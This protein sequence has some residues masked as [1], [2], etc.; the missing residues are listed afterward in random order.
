MSGIVGRGAAVVEQQDR[1]PVTLTASLIP[2]LIR[3]LWPVVTS[4]PLA[5]EERTFVTVGVTV[6]TVKAGLVPPSPGLPLLSFQL[7]LTDT[8]AVEMSIA[9]LPL[10]V[11]V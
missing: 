4:P 7:A 3:T 6:S 10:K 1:V 9:G 2:R 8:E 11:A 5:T